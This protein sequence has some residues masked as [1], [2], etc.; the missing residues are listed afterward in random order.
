MNEYVDD[1]EPLA[2]MTAKTYKT[3]FAEPMIKY[4]KNL[5]KK[6]L[7]KAFQERNE[8]HRLNN[9]NSTLHRENERLCS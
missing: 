6:A 1:T 4:L 3:R 5:L 7:A 9:A 2:L 8:Y